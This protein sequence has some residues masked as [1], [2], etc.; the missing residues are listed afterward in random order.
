[1]AR[2]ETTVGFEVY[3]IGDTIKTSAKEFAEKHGVD[4]PTAQG[5]IKFLMS[6]GIAKQLASRK[7]EGQKGKPTNIYELPASVKVAA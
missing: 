5:F 2:N 4:Y 6:K 3:S 7:V 1:M